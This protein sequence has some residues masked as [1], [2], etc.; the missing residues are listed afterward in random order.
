[1]FLNFTLLSATK[2]GVLQSIAIG[3]MHAYSYLTDLA[4]HIMSTIKHIL[5][6]CSK[7]LDSKLRDV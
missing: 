6:C 1:M 3:G 7:P 4:L 2:K 5:I